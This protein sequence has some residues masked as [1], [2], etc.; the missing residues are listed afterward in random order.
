MHRSPVRPLSPQKKHL[1]THQT[2]QN[3]LSWKHSAE[4]F[5][6]LHISPSTEMSCFCS[7]YSTR[8]HSKKKLFTSSCQAKF[9]KICSPSRNP[10]SYLQSGPR[11]MFEPNGATS[12][13]QKMAE[14]GRKFTL[15][16]WGLTYLDPKLTTNCGQK[17][18]TFH[19]GQPLQ[20][21][22]RLKSIFLWAHFLQ[23]NLKL[24]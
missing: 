8:P 23:C 16:I 1:P 6:P 13:T 15:E 22:D 21:Y 10:F 7:I 4:K 20:R 14:N 11:G 12:N 18:S 19:I 3:F 9:L 5:F 24:Y 2:R 17:T